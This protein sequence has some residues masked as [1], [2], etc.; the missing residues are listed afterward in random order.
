MDLCKFCGL[1]SSADHRCSGWGYGVPKVA[2]RHH[3]AEV[4]DALARAEWGPPVATKDGTRILREC[5]VGPWHLGLEEGVSRVDEETTY[6]RGVAESQERNVQVRLSPQ[7]VDQ[8]RGRL[9][10]PQ[11]AGASA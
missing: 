8:V 10:I 4:E 11:S 2:L 9:G 7:M 1:E 5:W 6:F 3:R